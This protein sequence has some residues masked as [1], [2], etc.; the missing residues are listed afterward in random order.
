MF[1][2][3]IYISTGMVVMEYAVVRR[4]DSQMIQNTTSR[5]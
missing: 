1:L 4:S 5:R 3:L 2:G